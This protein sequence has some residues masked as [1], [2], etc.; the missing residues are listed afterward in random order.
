MVELG[1]RVPPTRSA[2]RLSF[3]VGPEPPLSRL[4]LSGLTQW[5]KQARRAGGGRGSHEASG[6]VASNKRAEW[7]AYF[8]R[9]G[10]D[11]LRSPP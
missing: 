3:F 6:R 8:A 5:N 4:F 1:G 10:S 7:Q 9:H 2:V 11:S